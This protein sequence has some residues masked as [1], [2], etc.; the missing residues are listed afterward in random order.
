MRPL[1]CCSSMAAR[2]ARID[3]LAQPKPDLL[4]FPDRRS[5]YWL[6]ELPNFS[7]CSFYILIRFPSVL[8][9]RLSK[10]TESKRLD[11][12]FQN[13]RQSPVWVVS[14][15]ALSARPSDRVRYLALP[16]LPAAGWQPER[17]LLAALSVAVRTAEASQRIC[18]L[19]HPKRMKK[20]PNQKDSKASITAAPPCS[21]SSRIHL[22]ATPKSNHSQYMLD[23]PVT[24]PVSRST[25]KAVASERVQVLAQP[26]PRKALFQGYDPYRVNAAARSANASPRV[27]ELCMPLPRKCKAK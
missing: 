7:N 26:K 22:L 13:N 15:A 27:L 11:P 17:P 24:C 25:R 20:I 10:L 23:R 12:T 9:P 3:R 2:I 14:T 19:A 6:D 18:Q 5:V 8:T 16:R 1:D 21:T 4:K